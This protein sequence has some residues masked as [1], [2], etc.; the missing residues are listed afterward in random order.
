VVFALPCGHGIDIAA[1]D[2]VGRVSDGVLAD[3]GHVL[4]ESALALV[5]TTVPIADATVRAIV[6]GVERPHLAHVGQPRGT[7]RAG[8]E[9]DVADDAQRRHEVGAAH[10]LAVCTLKL[11]KAGCKIE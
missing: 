5:A 1:K 2:G 9:I 10:V 11:E 3:A 7:C 6:V 8:D 4:V